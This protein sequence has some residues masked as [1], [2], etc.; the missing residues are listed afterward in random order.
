MRRRD[1]LALLGGTTTWPFAARA[2]PAKV[3]RIAIVSPAASVAEFSGTLD[4]PD[5][6][7][8][9]KDL[10]RL[11]YVEGRNLIVELYSAEGHW[12]R[13]SELAREVVRTKPDLIFT[14][15]SGFIL[16]FK[17][18]TDVRRHPVADRPVA[19]AVRASMTG[20]PS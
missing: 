10:R 3:L 8:F 6:R 2:Q 9:F 18:A 4:L 15:N 1:F 11:G 19:G 7:A 12:E 13:S 14:I 5:V 17:A 20:R 16:K